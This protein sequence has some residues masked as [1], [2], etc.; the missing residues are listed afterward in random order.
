[1]ALDL[2]K[3]PYIGTNLWQI[4]KNSPCYKHIISFLHTTWNSSNTAYFPGP[5][6][7]SIERKHFGLLKKNPYVICEKAD[8]IR[9]ALIAIMYEGKKFCVIIDR[10]Q[11]IYLLPLNLPKPLFQGTVMDGELV[12]TKDG[13]AFMIY[14]CLMIATKSVSHLSLT[15]RISLTIPEIAGIM[16]TS[17]DP[18]VVKVKQFWT[19]NK[20]DE[21]KTQLF[22]YKTDGIIL[23]PIN[24]PIQTGTH[25]TMFKW[26]PRDSN[27]IDF[28]IQSKLSG[29]KWGMYVQ[30]HGKLIFESELPKC[31]EYMFEEN[32][33]VECQYIH[34][35][36]PRWWR[37]ILIRTDKTHPNNR[38][39][40]YNTLKNI[41]ENI[42]FH[43]F[44]I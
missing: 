4:R 40:F 16:K 3:V 27:T 18:I 23:T 10:S 5:Q 7:I 38:R 36:E 19:L 13:Y 33:I 31:K 8:G 42:Q 44:K 20:F 17:K 29:N 39:T 43:E 37:P 35:E 2:E 1:M 28:Q 30:E 11:N 32:A 24:D 22:P 12:Q 21:F 26:K 34:W 14:D 25:E 15:E 6:P 41:S 9:H